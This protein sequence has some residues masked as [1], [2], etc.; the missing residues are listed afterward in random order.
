MYGC[1]LMFNVSEVKSFAN[2]LFCRKKLLRCL[3]PKNRKI[4]HAWHPG[5]VAAKQR[6]LVEQIYS[7]CEVVDA[8]RDKAVMAVVFNYEFLIG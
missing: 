2:F 1:S 8:R 7:T 4:L 5:V 3:T 6:A